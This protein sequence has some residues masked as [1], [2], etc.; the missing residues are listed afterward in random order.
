[1]ICP[2]CGSKMGVAVIQGDLEVCLATEHPQLAALPCLEI[3]WVTCK[4]CGARLDGLDGELAG[5]EEKLNALLKLRLDILAI[6]NN[7]EGYTNEQADIEVE[8]TS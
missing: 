5:L 3:L 7:K 2:K 1:M 6:L 4:K 8:S